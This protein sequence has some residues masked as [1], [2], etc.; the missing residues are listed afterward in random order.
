MAKRQATYRV[1]SD[2]VQGE[3]SYVVLRRL[4][5]SRARDAALMADDAGVKA[6]AEY[7]QQMI[8]DGVVEWDW[9]D[10]AGELLPLPRDAKEFD[11]LG[12]LVHEVEFLVTHL[13]QAPDVKN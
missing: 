5:Y 7:T 4:P 2:Q 3:G 8:V 11:D 9:V 12:L 10:D 13:T 1:F 6:E